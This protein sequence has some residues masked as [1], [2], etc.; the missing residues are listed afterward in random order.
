MDTLKAAF[1]TAVSTTLLGAGLAHGADVPH[2]E[3]WGHFEIT[4]NGPAT[5]NPFLDVNLSARFTSDKKAVEVAGFYDG[6]QPAGVRSKQSNALD[7]AE[8]GRR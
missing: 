2:V 6:D 5:G 1:F 3:Q 8:N 7:R 4:L